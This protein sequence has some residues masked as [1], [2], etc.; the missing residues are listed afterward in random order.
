MQ[1]QKG[2]AM[3][4]DELYAIIQ[5]LKKELEAQGLS[6]KQELKQE[7]EAHGQ[8]IEDLQWSFRR[9]IRELEDT[10]KAIKTFPRSE[11]ILPTRR[12]EGVDVNS[13]SKVIWGKRSIYG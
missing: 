10:V 1:V 6:L 3:T 2:T 5:E 4:V 7:L 12:P 11:T 13:V 8:K 9:E